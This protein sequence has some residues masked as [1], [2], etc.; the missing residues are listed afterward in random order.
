MTLAFPTGSTARADIVYLDEVTQFVPSEPSGAMSLSRW[1]K[2]HMSHEIDDFK[3]L[4][5]SALQGIGHVHS[6]G[7]W[8]GKFLLSKY[9]VTVGYVH[10][11]CVRLSRLCML[12]DVCV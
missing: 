7:L 11:G 8:L 3:R 5:F 6:R 1:L 2:S 10:G 4:G 9:V 12:C